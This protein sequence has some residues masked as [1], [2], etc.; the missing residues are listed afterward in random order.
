LSG[1][2]PGNRA[3]VHELTT[4]LRR[5]LLRADHVAVPAKGSTWERWLYLAGVARQD[6]AAVRLVE[7]HLDAVAILDELGR[8]DVLDEGATWGVWAA[9]PERLHAERRDASWRLVGD[10]R[11]CSGSTGLDAALVTATAD[12]G[13]RLFVVR[14]RPADAGITVD[15]GSWPAVGMAATASHTLSFDVTVG[16]DDAIGAPGA[17]V[18]RPGF[19]WGGAGVAAC[20]WGG[21]CGVADGLSHLDDEWSQAARGRIWARLD[22]LAAHGASVAALID[23]SPDDVAALRPAVMGWRVV[24]ADTARFVV[25]EAVAVGGSHPLC[26]DAAHARRVADLAVY[27]TQVPRD[28]D[29]AAYLRARV[30]R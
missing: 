16:G 30:E 4:W 20:W 14:L 7:G 13:P 18:E 28:R 19:W 12:D 17:Y 29:A 2:R 24:A 27:S 9:D 26:H 23:R 8:R 22:S 6:I 11:Y 25:A 21:G 10:K 3:K 15:P 5:E 1:P